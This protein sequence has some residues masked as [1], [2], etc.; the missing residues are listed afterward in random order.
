MRSRDSSASVAALWVSGHVSSWPGSFV[1]QVRGKDRHEDGC[2]GAL[3]S[4]DADLRR[5]CVG[6]LRLT[7]IL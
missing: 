5:V 3:A 7:L 1:L 4:M 6:G 2:R